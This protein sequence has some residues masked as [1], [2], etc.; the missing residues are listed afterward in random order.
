MSTATAERSNT[1]RAPHQSRT[2]ATHA[3]IGTGDLHKALEE[4]KERARLAKERERL[5]RFCEH[6][7]CAVDQV[8]VDGIHLDMPRT[9][10]TMRSRGYTVGDPQRPKIQRHPGFTTWWVSIEIPAGPALALSF[11]TPN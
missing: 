11:F 6:T 8:S 5:T 2:S 10:D 7:G 3:R 1:S 4:S 9:L